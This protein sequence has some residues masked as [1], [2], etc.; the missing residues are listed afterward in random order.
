MPQAALLAVSFGTTHLEALHKS[1]SATEN[2]LSNAFPTYDLKR[3][4]TSTRVI[5]KLKEDQGMQVDTV[6]QALEK[7]DAEGYQTVL[8]QPLHIIDGIEYEKLL[9][10]IAPYYGK[11]ARL[12]IGR[13]LLGDREDCQEVAEILSRELTQCGAGEALVLMGHGS[14]H[15]AN[16]IYLELDSIFKEMGHTNVFVATVEGSPDIQ[17]IIPVLKTGGIQ[18][19]VLIPF[20]LVAGE[21]ANHDMAGDHPS[22]WK[23]VLEAEGITVEVRLQGLGEFEN[24]RQVYVR[25][26]LETLERGVE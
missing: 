20:M 6:Q 14:T 4:F 12:M 24:I 15:P 21:H 5:R 8:V 26:A 9:E 17:T 13:P 3:A 22:S 7:L 1:I 19:G 18:K 2:S 16:R 11:F 10:D 23:S 25:H